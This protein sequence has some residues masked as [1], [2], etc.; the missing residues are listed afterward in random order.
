MCWFR[1]GLNLFNMKN[2]CLLDY[3][4]NNSPVDKT[5]LD[6]LKYELDQRIYYY[7]EHFKYA[8]ESEL[9]ISK[10]FKWRLK[11]FFKDIYT[12]YLLVR[13]AKLSNKD[14]VIS[15]AYFSVN[16][17]IEEL[18]FEVLRPMHSLVIGKKTVGNFKIIK[19]FIR[20]DRKIRTSD[21]N[22]L[23]SDNF[24]NKLDIFIDNLSLYYKSINTKALIV[25]NDMSF[26]EQLNILAF[27]KINKPSFVFLHGLPGRYNIYDENQTDYLIVW[28][29]KIKDNYVNAGFNPEK[30]LI[31]GHPF[32]NQLSDKKL[33]NNHRD[34]L[35][36]SKSVNGAPIRDG[37]K[38][39]D[40]GGL[41]VYLNQ[42]KNVLE[43]LGVKKVRLRVHPSE[44]I[45]WYFR[46]IDKDFFVEDKKPLQESLEESTLVVGSTSTIL[47]ESLY[48]GVNYIVY[49]PI[50]NGVDLSGYPLVSPF[51]GSDYRVPVAKNEKELEQLLVSRKTIDKTVFHD[52]IQTPFNIQK[53]IDLI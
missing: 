9:A 52:Y 15:N 1:G 22:E 25:P 49:E 44:N 53:I 37:V 26:F 23:I 48:Y 21:L 47:L 27:K 12:F 20:I 35:V 4:K 45:D 13:R 34:I 17:K 10:T 50:F 28:G 14:I 39:T 36:I 43:K 40:R 33:R 16:E 32:Y 42:I 41:I 46:F 29:K 3:L 7:G 5:K 19:E 30:I 8:K 18:G 31:S 11:Y 38:L 2:S 51:D 24:L 6:L